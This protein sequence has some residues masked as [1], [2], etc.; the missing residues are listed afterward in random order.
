[1]LLL[2][3]SASLSWMRR[4][5]RLDC[6]KDVVGREPREQTGADFGPAGTRVGLPALHS[7]PP[8]AIA[9]DAIQR[10]RK[11]R[12]SRWTKRPTDTDA[13][14][15]PVMN[16]RRCAVYSQP[17]WTP[18]CFC[19]HRRCPSRRTGNGHADLAPRSSPSFSS[20]SSTR[21]MAAKTIGRVCHGPGRV[22]MRNSCA[23][24]IDDLPLPAS[25]SHGSRLPRTRASR[26][27][28]I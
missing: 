10:G 2:R 14:L 6:Q 1:M 19:H 28:A 9:A 4:G 18:R 21:V 15:L 12:E 16:T 11:R 13:P 20:P 22:R 26:A 3:Y 5:W 24:N 23:E 7:L 8:R 25:A 17:P 27:P